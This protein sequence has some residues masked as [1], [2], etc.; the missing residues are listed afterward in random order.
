[1]SVRASADEQLTAGVA[2][3]EITDREAGPVNDPL[4]VKALVVKSPTNS[5]VLITVDAVAIGEI[6][7]IGNDYLPTVRDQLFTDFG[8]PPE[9]VMINASHCHGVVRRDVADLT[10]QAVRSAMES[11]EQVEIGFGL[12]FENTISENRRLH[13]K[14]GRTIDVRHAYALPPDEEVIGVGPI[15][16]AIGI[17]KINR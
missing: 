13:L 2:K 4:F 9:N 17:V 11:Q 12:G 8:I 16:P 1:M 5:L 3:V 6:G 15:D 7:R 14:S 10:V